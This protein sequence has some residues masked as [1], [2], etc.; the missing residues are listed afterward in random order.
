MRRT[1]VVLAIVGA[2][3]FT[4]AVAAAQTT[5]EPDTSVVTSIEERTVTVPVNS[6]VETDDDDDDDSD[7]TGL[8]G[9][10]GLLGLAGLA[11]LKRRQPETLGPQT[12]TVRADTTPRGSTSTDH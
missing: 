3:T 8:W 6:V 7:K 10:L 11:G 12:G 2:S 9:L 4:S 1:L 5:T